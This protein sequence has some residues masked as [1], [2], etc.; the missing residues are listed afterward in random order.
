MSDTI[1]PRPRRWRFG[2]IASLCLNVFLIG[3]IVMGLVVARNRMA[4]T[5][6]GGGGGLRPEIVLQLLPQSG[7]RKMCDVLAGRMA[8]FRRLG[9]EIVAA[10][11]EMFRAF[12][13]EPYDDAA[14]RRT[15]TRVAAAEVALVREREA[16]VAELIPRL[17]AEE[18]KHFVAEVR[19][20]FL[21][22]RKTPPPRRDLAAACKEIGA[23]P[24]S[25]PQ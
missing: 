9:E 2:L 6:A 4:F 25:P 24:G 21:S 16:T 1:T 17:T 15:L 19:R 22:L 11:R 8:N 20:R 12:G 13:A 18:R 7:A 3:A 23:S 10:R 14:F 5:A